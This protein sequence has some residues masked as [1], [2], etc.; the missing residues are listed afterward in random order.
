MSGNLLLILSSTVI[1][2]SESRE[3]HDILI[4]ARILE[5]CESEV[6]PPLFYRKH[7]SRSK[8]SRLMYD[9]ALVAVA[10]AACDVD[11]YKRST[12]FICH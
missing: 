6:Y 10:G 9:L 12:H 4:A 8:L 3:T 7:L 2:G 11:H 1:L 5:S